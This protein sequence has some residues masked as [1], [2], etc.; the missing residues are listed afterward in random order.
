MYRKGDH[1]NIHLFKASV[2]EWDCM[3]YVIDKL[4]LGQGLLPVIQL[5]P[6]STVR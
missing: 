6:V 3:C 4:A 5:S 1:N 2:V